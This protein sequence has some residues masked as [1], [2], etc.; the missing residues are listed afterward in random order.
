MIF[1]FTLFNHTETQI[2]Q[3]LENPTINTTTN[4]STTN[5]TVTEIETCLTNFTIDC[6]TTTLDLLYDYLSTLGVIDYSY[7]IIKTLIVIGSGLLLNPHIIGFLAALLIFYYL[8]RL[9]FPIIKVA[10]KM[11]SFPFR[12][13]VQIVRYQ[14]PKRY[15]PHNQGRLGCFTQSGR[16]EGAKTA[17]APA[18]STETTA[19]VTRPV[20]EPANTVVE[21]MPA[22]DIAPAMNP[23]DMVACNMNTNT[24]FSG[25]LKPVKTWFHRKFP[26]YE[27]TR[28]HLTGPEYEV[29][30][31]VD[32]FTWKTTDLT[33]AIIYN[34]SIGSILITHPRYKF[35]RSLWTQYRYGVRIIIAPTINSMASGSLMGFLNCRGIN[36]TTPR[37]NFG[38]SPHG[39]IQ[40]SSNEHLSFEIPEIGVEH[41]YTVQNDTSSSIGQFCPWNLLFSV[42]SPLQIATGGPTSMQYTVYCQLI[43]I[44]ARWPQAISATTQGLFGNTTTININK[45]EDSALP[46]NMTGDTNTLSLPAFGMDYPSDTRQYPPMIMRTFQKLNNSKGVISAHKV[47]NNPNAMVESLFTGENETSISFLYSRPRMITDF[48]LS[49]TDAQGSLITSF[50]LSLGSLTTD[51]TNEDPLGVIGAFNLSHEYDNVHIRFYIPKNPYF[52]GKILVT[53][54]QA[55][56]LPAIITSGGF[57]MS[58]APSFIID[59]STPDLVHEWT[60]PWLTLN[61]YMLASSFN[62]TNNFVYPKIGMYTLNPVTPSANSPSSVKGFVSLS[63][64]NFRLLEPECLSIYT[65]AGTRKQKE[66]TTRETIQMACRTNSAKLNLPPDIV[67]T[68]TNDEIIDMRQYW[69]IPHMFVA[70]NL[71]NA[72]LSTAITVSH[73]AIFSL[74]PLLKY[75]RFMAGSIRYVLT[76]SNWG[77]VEF[78]TIEVAKMTKLPLATPSQETTLCSRFYGM[79][80]D[81]VNLNFGVI[82]NYTDASQLDGL[83]PSAM[84]ITSAGVQSNQVQVH[85]SNPQVVI[86]VPIV[87]PSGFA[88]NGGPYQLGHTLQISP[89]PFPATGT[90]MPTCSIAIAVGDDFTAHGLSNTVQKVERDNIGSFRRFPNWV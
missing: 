65:Q 56:T 85:K 1:I 26:P 35:L 23:Q 66:E 62:G 41:W 9:I 64:D 90:T 14:Y 86:D 81:A 13:C 52:N 82:N 67:F 51:D 72:S 75:Y 4:T 69:R 34:K 88:I 71:T 44:R 7:S 50:D 15:N 89:T 48:K 68:A 55:I 42:L 49:S 84:A 40:P 29:H 70:G 60:I 27:K 21:A 78:M 59:L 20:E 53:I 11:I 79:Q 58:T 18:V 8:F 54:S 73:D 24:I 12:S 83:Y 28:Y 37:I 43:N 3:P 63:Y 38:Y 30:A 19:E 10:F 46:L 45:M 6:L 77:N 16:A 80:S 39:F 57:N 25:P 87:T 61:E 17:A 31:Q 74:F 76:F 22:E 2:F 33:D 47:S 32:T 36:P 5:L